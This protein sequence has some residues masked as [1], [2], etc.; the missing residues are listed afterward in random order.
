MH[1]NFSLKI[2]D[3]PFYKKP[4]DISYTYKFSRE[5]IFAVFADNLLATKIK[6]SK[7]LK[8]SQRACEAQGL[9][10]NDEAQGLIT[11][12]EAQGLIT[13]DEAQGLITNDPQ[14]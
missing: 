11:N 9:I 2:I 3:S 13:N 4:Q 7:I 5:V 6:S 12:D 10:T 8:Q 1:E 14:K